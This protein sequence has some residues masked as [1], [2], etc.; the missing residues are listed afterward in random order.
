MV[1]GQVQMTLILHYFLLLISNTECVACNI[2]TG[3]VDGQDTDESVSTNATHM[4]TP[5]TT[6]LST[7]GRDNVHVAILLTKLGPRIYTIVL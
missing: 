2:T 6:I 1:T 5:Y 3:R 4:Y 7:V